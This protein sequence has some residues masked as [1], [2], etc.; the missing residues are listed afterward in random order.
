MGELLA[1][2]LPAK[3]AET[4]TAHT[5]C[6]NVYQRMHAYAAALKFYTKCCASTE[7]CTAVAL[8]LAPLVT[9]WQCAGNVLCMLLREQHHLVHCAAGGMLHAPMIGGNGVDNATCGS[10][11]GATPPCRTAVVGCMHGCTCL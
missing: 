8:S 4:H 2:L 10:P 6:W 5:H 11:D 7:F 3:T 9:A 1:V